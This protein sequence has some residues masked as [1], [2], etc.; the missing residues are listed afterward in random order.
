MG[1]LVVCRIIVVKLFV[2]DSFCIEMAEADTTADLPEVKEA[3]LQYFVEQIRKSG[4]YNITPYPTSTPIPTDRSRHME[5]GTPTPVREYER[6]AT[7]CDAAPVPPP[8]P[9]PPPRAAVYPSYLDSS[10]AVTHPRIPKLPQFSGEGRTGDCEFE[11]WKYDLNCLLRSGMYPHHILQEAIRNS[12]KGKA[13]TVLLHLGEW[14][15]ISDIIAELEAI[16]GNVATSERLKEEF[17]CTRQQ[18]NETVAEYSLRLERLLTNANLDLDRQSKNDMLRNRLWSGLRDDELRNVTRY[19]FESISDFNILR[20]ELR[21]IE[22]DFKSHKSPPSTSVPTSYSIPSVPTA[23]STS[24]NPVSE[25]PCSVKMSAVEHKILQQLEELTVQMKKLNTRVETMEK[26]FTQLKKGK[27]ETAPRGNSVWSGRGR[28]NNQSTPGQDK[29]KPD[30]KKS[31]SSPSSKG[32]LN[33]SRPSS[34]GQ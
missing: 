29:G 17:Y 30:E 31:D 14:A 27:F 13:R 28:Q 26:E 12:L 33:G 25:I 34:K 23:P 18:P 24:S 11:V 20:R 4:R 19:K 1:N 10:Y 21:Q 32:D 16:Y 7:A 3:E 15:S 8:R 5:H 6:K 22:E 9:P 2:P